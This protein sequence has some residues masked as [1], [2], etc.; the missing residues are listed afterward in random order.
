[1]VVAQLAALVSSRIRDSYI[2][3]VIASHLGRADWPTKC[4]MAS[5]ILSEWGDWRPTEL[6]AAS[7][8]QFASFLPQ[9]LLYD[10]LLRNPLLAST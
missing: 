5:I 4:R 2:R 8:E 1:L 9:L 7:A 6:A 3:S 10:Q